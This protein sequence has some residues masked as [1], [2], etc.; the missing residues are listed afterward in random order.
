MALSADFPVLPSWG[1]DRKTANEGEEF[2]P[3]SV[4]GCHCAPAETE[5][6]QQH[7]WPPGTKWKSSAMT[8]SLLHGQRSWM[9][10]T[11]CVVTMLQLQHWPT[12]LSLVSSFRCAATSPITHRIWQ[13]IITV[14]SSELM[15]GVFT[16]ITC[17]R[18]EPTSQMKRVSFPPEH[19]VPGIQDPA[20]R[21]LRRWWSYHGEQQPGPSS[22]L[23]LGVWNQVGEKGRRKLLLFGPDCEGL[24]EISTEE[25]KVDSTTVPVSLSLLH[26]KWSSILKC[27]INL[28]FF[29]F[30]VLKLLFWLCFRQRFVVVILSSIQTFFDL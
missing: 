6:P 24:A 20:K 13:H 3:E 2:P 10:L 25:K 17:G 1:P 21:H 18:T 30:P 9:L 15:S 29:N 11:V 5:S 23:S 27:R 19:A 26:K 14:M 4:W 7:W 12:S 8:S 28:R 22:M 16:Q